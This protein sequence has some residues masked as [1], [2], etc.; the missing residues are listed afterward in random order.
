MM[1]YNNH[2]PTKTQSHAQRLS[3]CEAAV[4]GDVPCPRS[5]YSRPGQTAARR[6]H[7]AL[8]AT[9]SGPREVD[10]N[11]ERSATVLQLCRFYF[12]KLH[13]RITSLQTCCAFVAPRTLSR[14]KDGETRCRDDI[15][16]RFFFFC[17][18][19]HVFDLQA[20]QRPFNSLKTA[21][22]DQILDSDSNTHD[23]SSLFSFQTGPAQSTHGLS[24][25]SEG[26]FDFVFFPPAATFLSAQRLM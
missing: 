15:R 5:I 17:F 19:K 16:V 1:H 7:P 26:T 22:D 13:D 8:S 4:H 18:N 20:Q 25:F 21:N 10:Q 14:I 23:N 6:P 2:T 24:N 9:L 11:L 3:S 12:E